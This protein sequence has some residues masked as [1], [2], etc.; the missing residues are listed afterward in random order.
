M[1]D[2]NSENGKMCLIFL[3]IAWSIIVVAS[4]L[5]HASPAAG[6]SPRFQPPEILTSRTSG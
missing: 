5:L 6:A 4:G 1:P 3:F 2:L